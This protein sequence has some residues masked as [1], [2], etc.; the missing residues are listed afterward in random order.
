MFRFYAVRFFAGCLCAVFATHSQAEVGA[1]PQAALKPI[2]RTNQSA[3][4]PL[5]SELASPSL[6]PALGAT[7]SLDASGNS[8][9]K[10]VAIIRPSAR[11]NMVNAYAAAKAE[12]EA[13]LKNAKDGDAKKAAEPVAGSPAAAPAGAPP[14]EGLRPAPQL[15]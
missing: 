6:R 7:T 11:V 1:D 3:L 14:A 5:T 4:R 2:A 13:K 9:K 12:A 15:Q 8:A 10:Q